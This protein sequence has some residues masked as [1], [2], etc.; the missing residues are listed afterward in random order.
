MPRTLEGL[1]GADP[2]C[3]SLASG[4]DSAVLRLQ[5]SRLGEHLPGS[6]LVKGT[7]SDAVAQVV[8]LLAVF[9]GDPGGFPLAGGYE[10]W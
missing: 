10:A 4:A 9:V 3:S 6:R 1:D 2:V 7:A 5:D 8:S